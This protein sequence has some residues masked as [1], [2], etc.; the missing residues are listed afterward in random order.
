M[1]IVRRRRSEDRQNHTP[2]ILRSFHKS[3][4][5]HPWGSFHVRYKDYRARR[6]HARIPPGRRT[7][8]CK[9]PGK[10]LVWM[11]TFPHRMIH[12]HRLHSRRTQPMFPLRPC[13]SRK[14]RL[15]LRCESQFETST[16]CLTNE[17]HSRYDND[18]WEHYWIHFW[19][20]KMNRYDANSTIYTWCWFE[21]CCSREWM[22]CKKANRFPL[23]AGILFRVDTTHWPWR[24]ESPI[25]PN[26]IYL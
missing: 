10:S 3:A 4:V 5:R 13:S 7:R 15:T 17:N 19:R 26:E 14:I 12:N 6:I 24:Q 1:D 22:P 18:S 16:L 8:T 21:I 20:L 2:Y 11:Y 9:Y 23:V 25:L